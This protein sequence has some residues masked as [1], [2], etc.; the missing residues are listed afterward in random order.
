MRIIASL[1]FLAAGWSAAAVEAE[2]VYL[3]GR[4]SDDAQ[5]W[6]FY[7]TGGRNSGFWTKIAVPSCWEQQGFGTYEYGVESRPSNRL[8]QQAKV[9]EEQGIYRR[10]FTVPAAW[11]GRVVRLVFDGV[12]TDT[13]VTINGRP[14]GPVHQG[15]FYQFKYDIT[16]KL[17]FDGPNGL[18]VKVSKHSA[19]A[20]VNKAERIG[21]YWN[22]G[23]IFRPVRL[24]ALPAQYIDRVAIDAKADGSFAADVFLGGAQPAAELT[25][26]LRR[27]DGTPIGNPVKQAV[28]AGATQVKVNMVVP[29]PATWT[30]ETP[31]LHLAEFTLRT[32]TTAPAEHVVTQR[33]GFRTFELRPGDGLY[34]NGHKITMKGV[35]RHSFWPET[36]R[37]LSLT[38]QRE[39]IRMIKEANMNAV[40]MSHYPP[41]AEF[42]DLCDEAGLYVLDELAGW[43]GSYDT[44]TGR[45]LI[46]QII[47]RDVNHPSILFWDNGNEGGWN[48]ENDDEFAKHDPQKRPVL[49]PGPLSPPFPFRGMNTRHYREYAETDKFTDGPDIFMPTEFLHGLYDGGHAAGLEDFWKLMGEKPHAAGGFLW[50][51]ADEG[52]VRT[53]EGGRI[54]VRRDLA[55]DGIVGPHGE[56]EGSYSAIKDIWSPVQIP[57]ATLPE[58]F[59]GTLPV[60]NRYDFLNL[61]TVTFEWRLMK[62]AA[63][64]A[65][66]F[67][68]QLVS[69][70]RMAGPD[71]AARTDG[72]LALA[73]PENWRESDVLQLTAF[74]SRD[75]EIWTWT[76]RWKSGAAAI[77]QAA[78]PG[79]PVATAPVAGV[80]E[81]GD[82]VVTAGRN[83]ARFSKATGRLVGL[84]RDGRK[85]SLANGP[86][87]TA[88]KR[89]ER[90]FAP[91]G[92]E[93]GKLTS[94]TTKKEGDAVVVTAK[95][96]GAFRE[97]RWTIR[98]DADVRLDYEFTGP[99]M[100]D[101][102]G[103]DFDYPEEKMKSK[104]WFGAGPYRVWANRL[105]GGWINRW[106]TEYN[107]PIPGVSW[108]YPEFKGWFSRW[109]WMAF[110]TTEGRFAFLNDGGQPYVGVYSPRDGKNN[111]VLNIPRLGL[112]VYQVITGIGTKGSLPSN[113]GPQGQ[114]QDVSGPVKGS[115][116]IRLLDQ[117]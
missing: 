32:G 81:G 40:R 4:G 42:L 26:Q 58:D 29:S 11:R 64:G 103:V 68:R 83:S 19:N 36:G 115:L 110:T 100:V 117:H 93:A 104:E 41:D 62:Y 99:G 45:R 7:C 21:D 102:L 111:P 25:L 73:L 114:P 97:V 90:S 89:T 70:G 88:Y 54:D 34:V 71:L 82:L 80:D 61:N 101:I 76:W 69:L 56:K 77:G 22:F 50:V 5:P 85:I 92:A 59:K 18:E 98:P 96:D 75:H 78:V 38:R 28:P 46:G 30:A 116:V 17:H 107:D 105:R 91:V 47:A 15:G 87:L 74:D 63:P 66:L 106:D 109:E 108:E 48:T 65:L 86:R 94:F 24:E 60:R 113:L 55:P 31:N 35:C 14:A 79:V 37:T 84:E 57:L 2:T 3:S 20:S 49:H 12:M 52:V 67:H 39:D 8:A 95:Y 1:L 6:D 13:E 44:P 53:D 16:D 9:P 33:F 23:G 27:L 112:G 72:S 51:W 43:Q 10:E